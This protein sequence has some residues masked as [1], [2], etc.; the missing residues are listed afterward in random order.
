MPILKDRLAAILV[1]NT[2]IKKHE[3]SSIFRHERNLI[4]P[5]FT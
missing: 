1:H 3:K 2:A 5:K 4:R